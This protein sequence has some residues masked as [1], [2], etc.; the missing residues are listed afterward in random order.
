[1]EDNDVHSIYRELYAILVYDLWRNPIEAIQMMA[2]WIWL[3]RIMVAPDLTRRILTLSSD[4]IDSVGNEALFCW[5][6]VDNI[7]KFF[8]SLVTNLPLTKILLKKDM[9]IGLFLKQREQTIMGIKELIYRVCAS[10]LKD[11]W[12]GAIARNA[13]MD[14]SQR[15][16]SHEEG[17]PPQNA[18]I[19]PDE[20]SLFITFSRGYPVAEWEVREFFDILFGECIESFYM[21]EVL[22]EHPL[23]ANIVLHHTSYI[24]AVLT[25]GTH[26]KF[27]INGKPVWMRKFTPKR[28]RGLNEL[29][30]SNGTSLPNYE[31]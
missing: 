9:P 27:I 2:I 28:R 3:E 21:P 30:L 25:G 17:L 7:N 15:V 1:M 13:H 14:F 29:I 12:D 4:L 10:C 20:R 31:L 5:T 19:Q 24:H 26:A 22:G 11:I 18:E 6:C 16:A 23:F 8:S